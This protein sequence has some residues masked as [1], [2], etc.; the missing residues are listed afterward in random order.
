MLLIFIILH[1][2]IATLQTVELA[3]VVVDHLMT[4]GRHYEEKYW[5]QLEPK[6]QAWAE[7]TGPAGGE[8]DDEDDDE[9]NP[10]SG[11]SVTGYPNQARGLRLTGIVRVQLTGNDLLKQRSPALPTG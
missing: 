7:A 3:R 8:D 5:A 9:A 11:P 4:M 6:R 1:L 10:E 2:Y